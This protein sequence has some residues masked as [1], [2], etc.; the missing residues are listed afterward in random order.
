M[1]ADLF[2]TYAVTVVATMFLTAIYFS[3]AILDWLLLYPLVIG[4]ACIIASVI[5]TYFVRL[6]SSEN[7]MAA[8][9]KGFIATA[10]ISAVALWPI[11]ELMIGF[12]TPFSAG[13]AEFTG[14]HLFY[15][16]L[17]GLVVTGL[18]IWITEYYT[19]TDY[20]PVRNIAA[21]SE[22]GHAT[23][24]IQGLAVSM[25]ATALPVL[26]ICAGI[27]AAYINAGLFGIAI[28]ATAMVLAGC[29]GLELERAE[30]L[31]PGGSEFSMNLYS[32]YIGLSKSEYGEGDYQ[33]SDTFAMRASSAAAGK[34][35]QPEDVANRKLP[36]NKVGELSDARAR[37]MAALSAGA[38]DK[39]PMHAA[40]A[41]VNFEC[42]MQEQEENFQPPDIARCRASFMQ[43]VMKAEAAVKP[44]PMVRAPA[45]MPKKAMAPKKMTRKF[46]VY[47]PFDSSKLTPE[48]TRMILSA[49]DAAKSLKAK[50]VYLSGHTDRVGPDAYNNKLSGLRTDSVA[51][52]IRGGGI[53]GRM[54]GLGAFGANINAVKTGPGVRE[55]RNRRVEILISN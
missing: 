24:I 12:D 25:E 37:L 55:R 22:T 44:A 14:R 31:K 45:P 40:S 10:L 30:G 33:D 1:A 36:S 38:A 39:A 23:N 50:R 18:L 15:S 11:T 6:G 32:G 34:P 53:S 47:F 28:A 2:E 9:Y 13:G 54:L 52:V 3:G 43:A 41:Q 51:V 29:T 46:V 20:R 26:V 21:A 8:L 7:I 49:I 19:S 16:G 48:S 17:I 5:G 27:I 35:G 42:W 4:G